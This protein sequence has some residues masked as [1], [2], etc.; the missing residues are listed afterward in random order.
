MS[1]TA[2]R[3][4]Y[5]IDLLIKENIQLKNENA[6]LKQC[7]EILK[8][9]N[10][11]DDVILNFYGDDVETV[12]GDDVETV[13]GDDVETVVGDVVET[14]IGENTDT[15][16]V[17]TVPE[18]SEITH[19]KRVKISKDRSFTGYVMRYIPDQTELIM[20]NKGDEI[21]CIVD[22][23]SQSFMDDEGEQHKSLN[24]VY[25]NFYKKAGVEKI[26]NKNCWDYFKMDGKKINDLYP[27]A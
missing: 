7:V 16:V 4:E 25:T 27:K 12:V 24:M 18:E 23:N 13:L 9:Q 8:Q 17:E 21:K 1:S 5:M 11:D 22:Y 15:D 26:N 10:R 14:V 2:A 19:E 6:S 20:S 3:Y